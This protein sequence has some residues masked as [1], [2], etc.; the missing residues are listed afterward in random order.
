MH[1][2]QPQNE[3]SYKERPVRFSPVARRMAERHAV[4]RDLTVKVRVARTSLART[5]LIALPAVVAGRPR[6]AHDPVA[7]VERD[8]AHVPTL[9]VGVTEL[10]GKIGNLVVSEVEGQVIESAEGMSVC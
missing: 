5:S 10:S 4:A 1:Q 8:I 9:V 7:A 2:E 3:T 6:R